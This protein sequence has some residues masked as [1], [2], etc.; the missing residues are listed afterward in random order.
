M[1]SLALACRL[2]AVSMAL[3]RAYP[4]AFSP[5]SLFANGE[6]GLWY[7]VGDFSTLF[8]DAAG[9]TPVTAV[10]QPVGLILDKRLPRFDGSLA[11]TKTLGDGVVTVNGGLITITG[12]TTETRV[13]APGRAQFNGMVYM[14]V[15]YVNTGGAASPMVWV[16]GVPT[17][18]VSGQTYLLSM[19]SH[20]SS[21]ERVQIASGSATFEILEYYFLPGNHASQATTPARGV[22]RARY[23]L[24]TYS[25]DF[26]NAAWARASCAVSSNVAADPFGGNGADLLYPT[27]TGTNRFLYQAITA[28]AFSPKRTIYAKSSGKRWLYIDATGGGTAQSFYDLSDGGIGY[29]PAGYTAEIESVGGG[30]YKCTLT[31]NTATNHSFGLVIGA[32]DANG[33]SSV[34]ANGADGVLIFAADSR[35]ADLPASLPP[36]QR[37]AAATDYDTVGFPVYLD[38]D[39]MDDGYQT[40][41]ID[42]TATDKMTVW[43]GLRDTSTALSVLCEL[44][45]LSN[46]ANGSFV[47]Y[48]RALANGDMAPG[49]NTGAS[50]GYRVTSPPAGYPRSTVESIVFDG[51]TGSVATAMSM[52][53][54][55]TSPSMTNNGAVGTGNFGNHPLYL[56]SRG[57]TS[58][59][60]KG[61]FYGLI[62]RG[63]STETTQLEQTEQWINTR[64]GGIY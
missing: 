60:W 62:I 43:A 14:R 51:T 10:E 15:R 63:A 13:D 53:A 48:R 44:S 36:Y 25:E 33:S 30:W 59:R 9:T 18:P 34:T 6:Q 20:N 45:A 7:D 11:W 55:G 22:L 1:P 57:G 56:F 23:N 64:M 42:F 24:L 3:R 4:G 32:S 58:L 28:Q 21:L 54:N 41:S 27:S 12:A 39:G 8:Q 40:G 50:F 37:I 19:F 5:A 38:P 31:A 2:S 46:G 52:R 17:V 35:P 26:S 49:M 29:V 16:A 61:Q 47:V